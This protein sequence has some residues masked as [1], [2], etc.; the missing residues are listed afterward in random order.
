MNKIKKGDEVI[1]ISGKDRTKR[2]IISAVIKNNYVLVEG[3]NFVKKHV[4]PNPMNNNKGGV[5]SKPLPI[6]ISNVAIFNTETKKIDKVIIKNIDGNKVRVFRS[7]GT[8][9]SADKV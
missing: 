8:L 1:I 3:I 4:K 5:I 9:I 2:G 6:H 7:N